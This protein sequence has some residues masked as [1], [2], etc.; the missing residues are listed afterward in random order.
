MLKHT[1]HTTL[2]FRGIFDGNFNTK[3]LD[4]LDIS[5]SEKEQLWY[6]IH[7]HVL[8]KEL[9]EYTNVWLKKD[10]KQL[11]GNQLVTTLIKKLC[12]TEYKKGA[13][14]INPS[15]SM[16]FIEIIENQGSF[17]NKIVWEDTLWMLFEIF[18]SFG[19]YGII[20]PNKDLETKAFICDHFLFKTK[21]CEPKTIINRDIDGSTKNN[22]KEK[23]S[24]IYDKFAVK[25]EAIY[26]Q[27]YE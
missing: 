2:D 23:P 1:K 10:S 13:T 3:T 8:I 22:S 15:L 16:A 6:R 26:N 24:A 4:E 17:K 7:T 19:K 25:L 12:I 18:K 11:S 9:V 5:R 21:D 14:F 27:L 20:K